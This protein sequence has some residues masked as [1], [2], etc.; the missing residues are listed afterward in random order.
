[1][2]S[3]F[4]LCF[5]LHGFLSVMIG[6]TYSTAQSAAKI[7]KLRAFAHTW[8]AKVTA[9]SEE[10]HWPTTEGPHVRHEG[11]LSTQEGAAAMNGTS[12]FML[13]QNCA[14]NTLYTLQ[15]HSTWATS[16]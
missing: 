10:D 7:R 1:M 13:P 12:I 6:L 5:T 4:L 8:P 15:W 11:E 2:S 9:G 3:S 14:Q 16:C